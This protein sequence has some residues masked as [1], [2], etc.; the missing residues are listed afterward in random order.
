MNPYQDGPDTGRTH[1]SLEAEIEF[2]SVRFWP[3]CAGCSLEAQIASCRQLAVWRLRLH[4]EGSGCRLNVQIA[5]GMIRLQP[6][7]SA[8]SLGLESGDSEGYP[9]YAGMCPDV[10]GYSG[11][12]R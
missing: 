7:G 12:W 1:C 8:W 10:V 5:A 9:A 11:M 3:G 4:P 6:G 2:W